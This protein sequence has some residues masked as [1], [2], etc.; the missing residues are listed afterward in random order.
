[1]G[2]RSGSPGCLVIHNGYDSSLELMSNQTS[3]PC[4]S[5]PN[6]AHFG[7]YLDSGDFSDVTL[8]VNNERFHLHRII[9]ASSSD[10]FRAL[11]SGNW[12]ESS[13]KEIP[14]S[15]DDPNGVFPE[16]L[17]YMYTGDVVLHPETVMSLL[18]EASRFQISPLITKCSDYME[19]SVATD[20]SLSYIQ[21]AAA[22]NLTS[23][24]ARCLSILAEAFGFIVQEDPNCLNILSYSQL[25][26]L[27]DREVLYS[28]SELQVAQT[29]GRYCI[30]HNLHPDEAQ[31][32][33]T[34]I[35]WQQLSL[36]QLHTLQQHKPPLFPKE[37]LQEVLSL[38]SS[39]ERE[40]SSVFACPRFSCGARL[41]WSI[42]NFSHIS[43]KQLKSPFFEDVCG[44][45]WQV[46]LY[47]KGSRGYTSVYLY[48]ERSDGEVDGQWSRFTRFKIK[49]IDPNTGLR[50]WGYESVGHRFEDSDDAS[51]LNWG[52]ESFIQFSNLKQMLRDD[53][54]FMRIVVSTQDVFLEDEPGTMMRN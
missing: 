40:K 21:A 38:H 42:P 54:L 47:P 34:S 31:S 3:K 50:L 15:W 49:V 35:R 18:F 5:F 52:W 1:M 45:K 11:F 37:L 17:K 32:L 26:T 41:D 25:K 7:H 46:V 8:V 10:F 19:R 36:E 4:C 12:R 2:G 23:V 44:R 14:L 24:E 29:V 33:Y 6:G 9:L 53:T 51:S 27:V 20:C 39:D 28:V 48:A 30:H 16:L 22:C 43:A 13:Q